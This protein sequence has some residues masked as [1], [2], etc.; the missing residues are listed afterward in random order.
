MRSEEGPLIRVLKIR[1]RLREI[2]TNHP[3]QGFFQKGDMV[4]L[5]DKRREKPGKHGK[6]DSL[7]MGPYIIH[8]V[9]GDNSFY[10]SD[11]DGEKQSLPV[12]GQI[13]KLFFS[14]NI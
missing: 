1:I 11:M 6:F 2:L 5:W 8:D 12:N 14:E 13:L 3:N 4:L 7:W 9:V 10:L